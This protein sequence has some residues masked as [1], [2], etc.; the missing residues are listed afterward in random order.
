MMLLPLEG[1][2]PFYQI[3]EVGP[4]I[5]SLNAAMTFG[6]NLASVWLIGKAS[7]LVLTLSGVL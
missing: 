2:Q 6:L 3:M 4:G 1:F 5:L 7:G